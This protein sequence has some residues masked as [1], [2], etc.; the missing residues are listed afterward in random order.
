MGTCG[1][2]WTGLRCTA[3]HCTVVDGHTDTHICTVYAPAAGACAVG[4]WQLAGDDSSCSH[5]LNHSQL[6]ASVTPA[7]LI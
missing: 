3:L 2:Q 7:V 1:L 4:T 6:A 5:R